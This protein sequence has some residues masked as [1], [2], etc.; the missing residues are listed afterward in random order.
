MDILFLKSL[1]KS[2]ELLESKHMHDSKLIDLKIQTLDMRCLPAK[3]ASK[4]FVW[5]GAKTKIDNGQR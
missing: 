4:I 3:K 5:D 2:T 1:Y